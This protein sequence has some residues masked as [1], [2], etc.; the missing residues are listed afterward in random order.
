MDLEDKLR[1]IGE[2]GDPLER[3]LLALAVLEEE[4][5]SRDVLVGTMAT[6]CYVKG[7]FS[8]DL[9]IVPLSGGEELRS[10]M[11][12]NGFEDRG[13][14]YWYSEE[15]D[16]L[17]QI[18]TPPLSDSEERLNEVEVEAPWGEKKRIEVVG[19]EDLLVDRINGCKFWKHQPYCEQA[20]T[21]LGAYLDDLDTDY[22][23][24]RLRGEGSFDRYQELIEKL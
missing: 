1:E 11:A 21:L 6:N 2:V 7:Y 16:V 4:S 3:A 18:N 8:E 12:E 9:D 22:M 5:G 14:G 10:V 13:Q 24:D 15:A 17:I 23:E 20:L 19:V